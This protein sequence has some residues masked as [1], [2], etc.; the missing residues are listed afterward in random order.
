MILDLDEARAMDRRVRARRLS[1]WHWA[2]AWLRCNVVHGEHWGG[3]GEAHNVAM[4][5]IALEANGMGP[6]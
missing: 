6:C 2:L 3:P 1:A 5:I 4:A